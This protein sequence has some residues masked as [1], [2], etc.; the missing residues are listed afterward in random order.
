[1]VGWCHRC[2]GHESEP[3]LGD[4]EG[5]GGRRAA[6]KERGTLSN[7][8]IPSLL[9]A[10]F[11]SCSCIC[12]E[13]QIIPHNRNNILCKHET[14]GLS[15]PIH[16]LSKQLSLCQVTRRSS[17]GKFPRRA[18]DVLRHYHAA[19]GEGRQQHSAHRRVPATQVCECRNTS[20]HSQKDAG[21]AETSRSLSS[22]DSGGDDPG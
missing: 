4:G 18:A 16:S 7:S 22:T 14:S 12:F 2:S 15:K 11:S 9:P 19:S 13:I 20:L 6:G 21:P 5:R 10:A 17:G 3:A 8:I 1:M